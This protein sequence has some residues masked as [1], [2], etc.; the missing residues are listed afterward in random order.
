MQV[1]T[2]MSSGLTQH[3]RGVDEGD[4]EPEV[5][6]EVSEQVAEVV[7][8]V[9]EGLRDLAHP[10]EREGVSRLDE[11]PAGAGELDRPLDVEQSETDPVREAERPGIDTGGAG[12]RES[13]EPAVT[14]PAQH[15]VLLPGGER[16]PRREDGEPGGPF[17]RQVGLRSLH[18]DRV[19]P[20]VAR[21]GDMAEDAVLLLRQKGPQGERAVHA[22]SRSTSP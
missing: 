7:G 11:H 3:S 13:G 12:E 19:P 18:H 10:C 2:Q 15:R 5:R 6:R 1:G 20:D 9:F 21:A 4:A 16:C 17:V 8:R 14:D 22:A